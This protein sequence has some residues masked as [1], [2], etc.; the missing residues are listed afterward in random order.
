MLDVYATR[1]QPINEGQIKMFSLNF[2]FPCFSMAVARSRKIKYQDRTCV[3][4]LISVIIVTI[5]K[6]RHVI[7]CHGCMTRNY[8]RFYAGSL[9]EIF[10]PA[11]FTRLAALEQATM[12]LYM[13]SIR[14]IFIDDI[15][16]N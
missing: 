13:R 2:Q 12:V 6:N 1:P 16:L 3:T 5:K 15:H 9:R 11:A 4:V 7:M 10:C 8:Q 14:S